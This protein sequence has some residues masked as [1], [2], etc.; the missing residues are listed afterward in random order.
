[1]RLSSS[2]AALF[3]LAVLAGAARA[4]TRLVLVRAGGL[5]GLEPVLVFGDGYHVYIE[6]L[7]RVP[8][9]TSDP[10]TILV[11]DQDTLRIS[12]ADSA[13]TNL[14][15]G[16]TTLGTLLDQPG[17]A[18]SACVP[19]GGN[20]DQGL[21][22]RHRTASAGPTEY[23]RPGSN[24]GSGTACLRPLPA[25]CGDVTVDLRV[26][27]GDVKL[28]REHLADPT[29]TSWPPNAAARCSVIGGSADCDLADVAVL[30]RHLAG[31]P[32][33]PQAVCTAAD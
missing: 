13:L 29:G 16:S 6:P 32:P 2:L 19:T 22:Y 20:P 27:A 3:G 25:I 31:L 15:L 26:D 5:D 24:A 18:V 17:A 33:G 11:F 1:M 9:L 8:Y 23:F 28:Y 30:R 14:A 4:D 12:V 10:A 21:V 7:R